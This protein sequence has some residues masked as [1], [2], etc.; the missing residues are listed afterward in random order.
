[1]WVSASTIPATF[2][3]RLLAPATPTVTI[4]TSG[5]RRAKGPDY[6]PDPA[7]ERPVGCVGEHLT[8]NRSPDDLQVDPQAR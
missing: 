1:M 7:L 2:G 4:K 8:Y 3:P 6:S 5:M